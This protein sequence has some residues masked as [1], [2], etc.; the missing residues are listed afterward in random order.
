MRNTLV[1]DSAGFAAL[2]DPNRLRIIELLHAAP[3][4]VGEV[5]AELG[6]RQPQATKHLQTLQRAGLVTVHPLGQRRIYA[7][8]RDAVSELRAQLEPLEH[9]HSSEDVLAGYERAIA[10]EQAQA[11]ADPAW[12]DGRALTLRRTLPGSPERVFAHW[13]TGALVRGWWHPDHFA[14]TEAVVDPRP[15]GELR[16]GLAEGDGARYV[17]DGRFESVRAPTR[18]EFTLGPLDRAGRPLFTATHAVTLR[19]HGPG[20]TELT[21]RIR[22]GDARPEAAPAL[23]GLRRGWEQLLDA[24]RRALKDGLAS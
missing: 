1:V 19:G 10:V 2:G 5:A 13:T 16:I 3:R 24:L 6:L 8:R 20:Q 17:S 22:V 15:G 21:L 11:A 18:L 14:V 4:A 7:L 12:A 23:A 9:G